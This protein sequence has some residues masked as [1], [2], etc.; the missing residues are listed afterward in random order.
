MTRKEFRVQIEKSDNPDYD[1]RFIM[2]ASSPDRVGDTIEPSAYKPNLGK[3]LICLWQH[4]SDQPIGY[5]DN[6]RVK[7]G[8]LLGDL[9]IASTNLGLMVRTLINE[10]VPLGASIGFSGRGEENDY[11]GINFKQLELHECSVVSVPCH[12]LAMQSR[13]L[14]VTQAK[15]LGLDLKEY[16]IDVRQS[17][18]DKPN[19]VAMSRDARAARSRAAK[20][21]YGANR[22]V[23]S[24]RK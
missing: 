10:N 22:A 23:K 14:I 4:K 6:L 5:W 9:K 12:Q 1:A 19:D 7:S 15:S 24:I 13:E 20:A 3:R 2:S 16:G 8:Q 17:D 11:G 21:I 18:I